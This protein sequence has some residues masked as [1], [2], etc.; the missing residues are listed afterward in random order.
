MYAVMVPRPRSI[1][2]A[3]PR[4]NLTTGERSNPDIVRNQHDQPSGKLTAKKAELNSGNGKSQEA[5]ADSRKA[6]GIH[7]RSD[8]PSGNGRNSQGESLLTWD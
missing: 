8:R 6:T 3:L 5:N 4:P 7:N 2:S 1:E